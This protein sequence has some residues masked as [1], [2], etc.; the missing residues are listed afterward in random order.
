[1]PEQR[2]TLPDR[3]QLTSHLSSLDQETAFNHWIVPELLTLWW[4]PIAEVEARRGGTYHFSWPAQ[5]WHLR[6]R[7]TDFDPATRL[8]Y[9]WRWD[10]DPE[11]A[12][13]TVDIR[14]DALPAGGTELILT[15]GPYPD[16][17]A[18]RQRRQ[19]HLDGWMY[20]LGRLEALSESTSH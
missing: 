9:T 18:G 8:A 16:T 11:D 4:P 12:E 6:G 10:H 17:E 3:I 19:E 15:H 2:D 1:M 7:F 14:F 5:A 20:F 13:T